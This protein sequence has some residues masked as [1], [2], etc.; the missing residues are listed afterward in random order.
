MRELLAKSEE[1]SDH[2]PERELQAVD[3]QNDRPE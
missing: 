2:V 3:M 1:Q